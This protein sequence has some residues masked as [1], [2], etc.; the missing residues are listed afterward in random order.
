M[1]DLEKK[2]VI[3]ASPLTVDQKKHT[4]IKICYAML[5]A[6]YLNIYISGKQIDV[7]LL[8]VADILMK[9]HENIAVV[10][11]ENFL[12]NILNTMQVLEKYLLIPSR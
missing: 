1:K 2:G 7:I 4:T 9:I 10:W 11:F 3:V 12:F 6:F 5:G 8:D